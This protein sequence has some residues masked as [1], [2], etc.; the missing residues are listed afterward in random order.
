MVIFMR[1]LLGAGGIEKRTTKTKRPG[2]SKRNPGRWRLCVQSAQWGDAP[3]GAC[4]AP[5]AW[6]EARERHGFV[7]FHAVVSDIRLRKGVIGRGVAAVR[8]FP[9]LAQMINI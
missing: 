2:A 3:G 5:M 1:L 8:R 7:G 6:N 9:Q 4:M